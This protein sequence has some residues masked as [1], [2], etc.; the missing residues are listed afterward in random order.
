MQNNLELNWIEDCN[1][2]SAGDSSKFKITDAKLYV[3]IVTLFTKDNVN[4]TKRLNDAFK[5]SVYWNS[6]QT[7]PANILNQGANIYEL[8]SASFQD[9]KRLFVFAYFIAANDANNEAV[10][11]II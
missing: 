9:V 10:I 4:L 6:Y 3:L 7:I 11:K 1:L 5:R 2:S 8:L